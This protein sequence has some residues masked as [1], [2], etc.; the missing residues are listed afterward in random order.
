[1]AN[2]TTRGL[3][4]MGFASGLKMT[5]SWKSLPHPSFW[6]EQYQDRVACMHPEVFGPL[7]N[8]QSWAR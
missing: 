2:G 5:S 6:L 4:K 7:F 3:Q 8:N 1:M